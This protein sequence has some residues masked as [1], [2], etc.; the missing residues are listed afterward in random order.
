MA[1]PLRLFFENAFYHITAGGIR[2]EKIFYSDNDKKIFLDKMNETADKYSFVC[3]AYCLMNNHYH[4]FIKTPFANLPEGMHYLNVSYAN[5]FRAKHNLVGPIFQGRYKSIVVDEDSYALIF[6]A[7]IH[8]NPLRAGMPEKLEDYPF[9]S[10]SDYIGKRRPLIKRLDTSLILNK[11]SN[12]KEEAQ[13]K[14]EQ[15]VMENADLNNPLEKSYRSI[16]LGNDSFIEKIKEKIKSIDENRK[17][18]ETKLLSILNQDEVIK[19]IS[20]C[21]GIEKD[22]IFKKRKGNI[23]RQLTIYLIKRYTALS[24]KEI[25]EIFDI[26]YASVSMAARRFREKTDSDKDISE[27]LKKITGKMEEE[28]E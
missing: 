16:A 17:I 12:N 6:S 1:R 23:Y 9:S 26:D 22:E 5:W 28:R 15:F 8:L 3:Y 27:M 14:Y 25:G 19:N 7:Y 2:K 20:L 4:L 21:F 18:K 24:L 10:Y 11:F 13:V